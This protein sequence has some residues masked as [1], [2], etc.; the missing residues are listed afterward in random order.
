ME[1]MVS[2]AVHCANLGPLKGQSVLV[3]QVGDCHNV[4]VDH[5]MNLATQTENVGIPTAG[6]DFSPMIDG[7]VEGEMMGQDVELCDGIGGA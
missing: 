4:E 3:E 5:V 7:D 6:H 1:T 2:A